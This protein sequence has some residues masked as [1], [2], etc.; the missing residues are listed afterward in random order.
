MRNYFTVTADNKLMMT[1]DV[2][3]FLEDIMLVNKF[4][5]IMTIYIVFIA[6]GNRTL[7]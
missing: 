2:C 7:K 3:F 6:A 5:N 1:N 4:N